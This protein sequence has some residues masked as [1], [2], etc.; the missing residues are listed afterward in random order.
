MKLSL[1]CPHG[2]V[3]VALLIL[4]VG[5]GK[6]GSLSLTEIHST[7]LRKGEQSNVYYQYSP[8]KLKLDVLSKST[9][10]SVMHCLSISKRFQYRIGIK[11]PLLNPVHV[12]GLLRSVQTKSIYIIIIMKCFIAKIY[13][14]D[15]ED[16]SPPA[17]ESKLGLAV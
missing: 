1:P 16:G 14:C 4:L 3:V 12:G 8:I 13:L 7:F 17:N 2:S 15:T 10:I 5:R 6:Q 11:N 9:A